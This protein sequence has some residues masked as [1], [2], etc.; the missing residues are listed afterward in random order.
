MMSAPI[1]TTKLYVPAPRSK[2][3]PRSHLIERLNQGLSGKLT[4]IS[5]PAG[6]GK[7][8]LVSEWLHQLAQGQRGRG[9]G[10]RKFPPASLLPRSPAQVGW[11]SLD[12]GDNDPIRFLTYLATALQ[13]IDDTLVQNLL[14]S[15]QLPPIEALMTILINDISAMPADSLANHKLIL[16][17]D[18]Y[19]LIQADVIHQSLEYLLE[20]QPPHMHL[21]IATRQDPPFALSR[22][23][24]RGQVTEIRQ[25]DLRFAPAEA[26]T[27]LNQSMGLNLSLEAVA[28]LE[29]RTEGWIAGLQL[30]ALSL[31]GRHP[32]EIA[33]FIEAFSGSHRYVIDY[34]VDE[35]IRQQPPDIR[36]FLSQTAILDRMTASLCDAVT[37]RSDSRDILTQLE[38]ANLFLTSLDDHRIWYRYHHLFAEFLRTE[39]E[40][41]QQAALH[42]KAAAWFEANDFLR[43]AVRHALASNN[44]NEAGRLI[45]LAA[46]GLL[47]T[48]RL[49]TLAGWLETLPVEFV[50]A[51]YELATYKGWVLWL[52]GQG[53]AAETFVEAAQ[54]SQ[55]PQAS[56][57]SQGKLLGLRACLA[58]VRDRAPQLAM[59]ALT[60]LE[61]ADVFYRG[62]ILLILGEAQNLFGDTAGA[63]QTF[64]QVLE[65]G[66]K[67]KD[68]IMT[69][70]AMTNMAEL[71]NWQ[72]KRREALA[73]CQQA[74]DQ[75]VDARGQPLPVVGLAYITLGELEYY[76][77]ELAQAHEH[78]QWG[79][80]LCQSQA[81]MGFIISGK[82]ALGLLQYGLGQ[83]Q[84][85]LA[86][87][88]EM[89]QLTSQSN[90]DAYLPL[91]AAVEADFQI[92]LG[93][94]AAAERW[95]EQVNLSLAGPLTLR[96]E[97]EYLTYARLLAAQ[98]QLEE[99][100]SLLTQ[101][102]EATQ[103]GGLYLFYMI[104]TILQA[105]VQAALGRDEKALA[106]LEKA[107]RVAAPEGYLQFFLNEGRPIAKLLPA[108][109]RVAPAFVNSLLDAFGRQQETQTAAS[110]LE[111]PSVSVTAPVGARME[112]SRNLPEASIGEMPG[113]TQTQPASAS[114]LTLPPMPLLLEPLS[115]REV[116]VL[117][118]V[119]IGQSNREIAET[120]VITAGT[121][122]KHLNNIFSKLEVKS[123]TQAVARARELGLV[124]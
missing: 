104:A 78:I 28:R 113:E 105:R 54:A 124:Q 93:N 94:I 99:A 101:L 83:A 121:V 69:I 55:P 75:F 9:V 25:E 117:N 44:L 15:R 49:M 72:G 23:R 66:Q 122:K 123:R 108:L 51:D 40:T 64:E 76:A 33:G 39:L 98:G 114:P 36:R 10:E 91:V 100:Q 102:E 112:H 37:A 59:Q 77:H 45:K 65:L 18:D 17:L 115:D 62:I 109:R 2:L 90:F 119:A 31:Q 60:L 63:A 107:L 85:G 81:M 111:L 56:P 14:Q 58:L 70:G 89:A 19:H 61:E 42:L 16:V 50:Q 34:L 46:D 103:A 106:S 6:F 95:A 97:L 26:N 29:S 80:E 20:H 7:T 96:S 110:D 8:T 41:E 47:H 82:L 21:V 116:E 43:D 27:F 13:T 118:L 73:L 88:Q 38:H 120:L 57:T 79:I 22:L 35:V 11:V 4:L 84:A 87:I 3:V 74:I 52:M 5:A 92:K 67:H 71:L 12:E 68:P 32:E 86:T 1:L 24:V 30:A 53:E 48:G